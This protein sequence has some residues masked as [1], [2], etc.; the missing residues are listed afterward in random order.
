MTPE[1]KLRLFLRA[2]AFLVPD[3]DS[4]ALLTVALNAS[5]TLPGTD[6]GLLKLATATV[7]YVREVGRIRDGVAELDLREE[8]MLR[9]ALD[10]LLVEDKEVPS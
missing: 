9:S 1:G 3:W 5:G 4:E 7:A 10:L 2:C 8:E 6:R